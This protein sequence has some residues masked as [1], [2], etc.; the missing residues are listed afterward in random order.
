LDCEL[1]Q[2]AHAHRLAVQRS[3]K[4]VAPRE[5]RPPGAGEQRRIGAFSRG[6]AVRDQQCGSRRRRDDEGEEE[7]RSAKTAQREDVDHAA[8][9]RK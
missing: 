5:D 1:E 4:R 3:F 9:D 6:W 8:A 2:I 7:Q